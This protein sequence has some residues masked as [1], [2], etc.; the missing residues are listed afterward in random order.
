MLFF[1][2]KMYILMKIKSCI[3]DL[4]RIHDTTARLVL[5]DNTE[6]ELQVLER[7]KEISN[8][9]S[10]CHGHIKLIN[11]STE[12]QNHLEY[13][14]LQNIEKHFLTSLQSVTERFRQIHLAYKNERNSAN[15]KSKAIFHKTSS[16]V[17][18]INAVDTFDNFLSLNVSENEYDNNDDD[19]L[20]EYFQLPA[21]K[22]SIDQKKLV[23]IQADN[24]RMI[25]NREH[26]VSK[27]VS[28]IVDLNIIFKDLSKLVQEQGT[29]LDRIDYNIESTQTRVFE[30]YKQLQ[31]AETFQRKNKKIYCILI[32]ASMIMFMIIL[33]IFTKF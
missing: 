20:D 4:L 8:L 19:T 29:I 3:N 17:Q 32:L 33:T 7:T 15:Q 5:N 30:G 11:S 23:M 18:S 13:S 26:E 10:S 2:P 27:I 22:N 16:N 9:I 21:S 28:S 14:M 25:Q 1:T 31:K 24:K 6:N 12:G